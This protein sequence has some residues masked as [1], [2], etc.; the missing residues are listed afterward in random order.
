MPIAK[1]ALPHVAGAVSDLIG[2][3]SAMETLKTRGRAL[4][5]DVTHRAADFIRGD[6][7]GDDDDV[8]SSRAIRKPIKRKKQPAKSSLPKK[9]KRWS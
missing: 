6:G 7:G 1:T 4:G 8:P 5:A 9:K 3:K 2:G